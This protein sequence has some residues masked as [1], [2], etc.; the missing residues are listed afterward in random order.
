[1]PKFVADSVETTGLKWVAPAAGGGMTLLTSGNLPSANS[2]TLS[3]ISQSYKD[4][5]FVIKAPKI[6]TDGLAPV[7]RFNGDTNSRYKFTNGTS[8]G[9]N[10]F[11]ESGWKPTFWLNSSYNDGFILC[12][13]Y[14]YTSST[15][16][17]MANSITIINEANPV[18]ATDV[19]FSSTYAAYN[20]E[21]AITSMTLFI[22][23][24]SA[25]FTGGTYELYG[26][27]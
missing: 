17:Q 11:D 6:S 19:R 7:I 9:N 1:V 16:W 21:T 10:A 23:G 15:T 3:T 24:G 8:S 18:S 2:L 12:N 27:N 5:R 14:D 20:Q 13:I 22:E 4:L 26:V 25:T